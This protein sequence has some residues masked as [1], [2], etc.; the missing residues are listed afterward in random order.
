[1]EEWV[2]AV[3]GVCKNSITDVYAIDETVQ[4]HKALFPFT[5]AVQ[6]LRV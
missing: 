6:P 3:P 2:L 5:S 1:M 4:Y